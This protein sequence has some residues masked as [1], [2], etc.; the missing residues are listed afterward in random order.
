MTRRVVFSDLDG[1]LLD[2]RTY[3][4]AGSRE[5]AKRLQAAGIPLIFCSAKTW[6]EQ[7]PLRAALGVAGPCIVENGSA[8]LQPDGSWQALGITA[9]AI[10]QGL[11]RI[12]EETGLRFQTFGEV[13]TAQVAAVTGL[14]IEAAALAQQR[15][16]SETVFTPFTSAEFRRFQSACTEAGLNA[17]MGGRFYTV[18]GRGADKGR[19]V[20]L[21]SGLLRRQYGEILTIGI[22]DSP[23]DAPMLGAVDRA[24]LVERPGGGWHEV[25]VP[26]LIHAA[27][28]GP[29]GF[30]WMV[31]SLLAE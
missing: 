12:R 6:G 11:G 24:Y 1:T 7:L 18:T 16:Y 20:R 9:A 19:A 22:G 13:E 29:A 10:R 3:S 14:S 4:P 28:P 21:L 5:A 31:E 2:A 25:T 23:N 27:A 15:E 30:S 17:L 8:I 26:G